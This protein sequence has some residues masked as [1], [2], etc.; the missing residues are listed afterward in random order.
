MRRVTPGKD[1]EGHSRIVKR[2]VTPKV[3]K[4]RRR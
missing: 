3:A 2:R 4:K 1:P